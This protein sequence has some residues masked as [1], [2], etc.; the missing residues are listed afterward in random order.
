MS[1]MKR[2]MN[3]K[4]IV[5]MQLEVTI[6]TVLDLAIGFTVMATLVKVSKLKYKISLS[7]T[8]LQISMNVLRAPVIVLRSV[9]TLMGV[10]SAP[11]PLAIS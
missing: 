4:S 3:V 2:L 5:T 7:D 6:A 1:V 10:T 8:C 11:V 9:R